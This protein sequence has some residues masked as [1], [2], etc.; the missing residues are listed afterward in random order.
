MQFSLQVIRYLFY[1]LQVHNGILVNNT[2]KQEKSRLF[3]IAL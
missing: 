1:V 3:V 2:E